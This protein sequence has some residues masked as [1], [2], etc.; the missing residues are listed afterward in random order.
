[1]CPRKRAAAAAQAR[2]KILTAATERVVEDGLAQVRI[3]TVAAAAGVTS[4]LVHYHFATK[5]RLFTEVL[6]YSCRRSTE[7]T[8]RRIAAAG[9]D[10]VDQLLAFLDRCLPTDARATHDWTLWQELTVLCTRD[11]EL[12]A[13]GA[14]LYDD[15]YSRAEEI[16]A[17]GVAQGL[18]RPADET[19]RVARAIVAMCDGLGSQVLYAAAGLPLEQ[20]R[21][22]AADTSAHVLG[23]DGP[24]PRR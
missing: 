17:T 20:A 15:L 13:A 22:I 3:A 10:A 14:R 21:R 2:D 9:D 19:A 1:M 24:L 23:H 12:A 11:P 16:I 7:L 8:T 18:L 6:A 4:G 5:E